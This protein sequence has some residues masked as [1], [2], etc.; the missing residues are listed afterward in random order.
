MKLA[1]C[2]TVFW[3]GPQCHTDL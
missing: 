1:H 3:N 2:H